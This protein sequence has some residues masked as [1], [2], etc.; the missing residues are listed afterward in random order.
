[1]VASGLYKKRMKIRIV[2]ES[3]TV[4]SVIGN[5]WRGSA[6]NITMRLVVTVFDCKEFC[7]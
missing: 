1:M 5:R 7:L 6:G 4:S 3:N 2:G